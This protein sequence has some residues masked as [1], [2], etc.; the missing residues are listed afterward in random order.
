MAKRLG[1]RGT[2]KKLDQDVAEKVGG[3]RKG[4]PTISAR[5]AERI[6]RNTGVRRKTAMKGFHAAVAGL[7]GVVVVTAVDAV[8]NRDRTRTPRR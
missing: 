1:L 3:R 2:L 4:R 5:A 8:L 6:S 7:V